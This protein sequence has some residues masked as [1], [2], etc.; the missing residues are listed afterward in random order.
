MKAVEDVAA[1][2]RTT[3]RT[4]RSLCEVQAPFCPPDGMRHR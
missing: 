2:V 4:G 3:P 1:A